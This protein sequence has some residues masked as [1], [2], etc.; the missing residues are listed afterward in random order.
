MEEEIKN[1][2]LRE[3]VGNYMFC[4]FGLLF[5]VLVNRYGHVGTVSLP[6]HT[7]FLA[8]LEQA[9]NQYFVHIL[10]L[11]TYKFR[12]GVQVHSLAYLFYLINV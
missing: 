9:V 4:W 8:K 7:F 10:S 12:E 1:K 2:T 11:L 6:N 3:T 5:Y